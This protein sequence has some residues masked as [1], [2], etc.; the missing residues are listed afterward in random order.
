VV[1]ITADFQSDSPLHPAAAG[2]LSELFSQGWGEPSSLHHRSSQ[3]RRLLDEARENAAAILGT[4]RDE[5][6]FIGEVNI[7]FHLGISGLL[8]T[9]KPTLYYSSID[10]ETVAAVARDYESRGGNSIELATDLS[11]RVDYQKITESAPTSRVLVWQSCNGETGIFQDAEIHLGDKD[12]IFADMTHSKKFSTLPSQWST[13]LWDARSW[14]GPRGIAILGIR[15]QSAWINPLPHLNSKPIPDSFSIP[16]ALA[17]VIALENFQKESADDEKEAVLVNLAIREF[18]ASEIADVDI[19]GDGKSSDPRKISLSFLGVHAEELL[20][21]LESAGFLV[22]SG[23]A[24]T[25][26]DLK[27]SHVLASMGVLTHGNIRLTIKPALKLDDLHKFLHQLKSS[28]NELR[29]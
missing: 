3:V 6:E 22:D 21:K 4:T 24:C 23:S 10:R 5:V 12:L 1:P 15:N 16:L 9:T 11:G 25:A 20:R 2:L 18:M 7:G 13:A 27:P 8:P 14:S 26:T 17:A 28:V 29:T 19:A